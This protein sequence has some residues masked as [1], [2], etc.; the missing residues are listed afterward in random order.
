VIL[1]FGDHPPPLDTEGTVAT[2]ETTILGK[3]VTF[4]HT[5]AEASG[6]RKVHMAEAETSL[7]AHQRLR[8]TIVSLDRAALSRGV[9]IV[10]SLRASD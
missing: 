2:H 6:A 3:T 4:T 5:E 7:G 1:Y 9:Q 8:V 10:E